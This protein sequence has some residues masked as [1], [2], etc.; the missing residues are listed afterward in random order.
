[1]EVEVSDKNEDARY[2][3]ERE[4]E[5]SQIETDFVSRFVDAL[6]DATKQAITETPAVGELTV[7]EAARWLDKL[8]RLET[9]GGKLIFLRQMLERSAAVERERCAKAV[10][11]LGDFFTDPRQWEHADV[12]QFNRF[13]VQ[14]ALA[15]I[16]KAA[17]KIRSG[18]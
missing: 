1:L 2:E 3:R 9:I 8:A 16:E 13:R 4:L 11:A 12:G 6:A 5:N 7:A 10:E 15:A 17:A 14:G 18:Q